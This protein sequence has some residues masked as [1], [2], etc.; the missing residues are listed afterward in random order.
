MADLPSHG[1]PN[2][3]APIGSAVS[4]NSA[5]LYV[6]RS[7]DGSN[8]V[9]RDAKNTPT[10]TVTVTPTPTLTP[11]VTPTATLT[12]TPTP[13]P[14][15]VTPTITPTITPTRTPTVTP[16]R[17]PTVTPTATPISYPLTIVVNGSREDSELNTNSN[18]SASIMGTNLNVSAVTLYTDYSPDRDWLEI[19]ESDTDDYND[20]VEHVGWGTSSFLIDTITSGPGYY[21]FRAAV[22]LTAGGLVTSSNTPVL[23]VNY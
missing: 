7:E 19:S 23:Y 18:Y 20:L 6:K 2:L 22:I 8:V 21:R 14:F 16:T 9:W 13:L 15:G 17:T 1:F 4:S 11:T 12:V 10:P 3:F 5:V